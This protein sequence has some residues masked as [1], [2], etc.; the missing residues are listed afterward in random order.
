MSVSFVGVCSPGEHLCI[1]ILSSTTSKLKDEIRRHRSARTEMDS[2]PSLPDRIYIFLHDEPIATTAAHGAC[3][4]TSLK[5]RNQE[6]LCEQQSQLQGEASGRGAGGGG[7]QRH[8]VKSERYVRNMG[9]RATRSQRS[10]GAGRPPG[11]AS[12][13]GARARSSGAAQ[14]ER[15]VSVYAPWP[16]LQMQMLDEG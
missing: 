1:V 16:G 14:S 12:G 5:Y 13:R 3:G 9:A 7:T 6:S 10:P 15:Y 2:D 4:V 8:A 11:E